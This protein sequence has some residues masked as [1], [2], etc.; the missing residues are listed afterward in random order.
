MQPHPPLGF[1]P[2]IFLVACAAEVPAEGSPSAT[3]VPASDTSDTSSNCDSSLYTPTPESPDD[4]TVV[5]LPATGDYAEHTFQVP[6]AQNWVN[7]GLY[8]KEGDIANISASGLWNATGNRETSAEGHHSETNRG[9]NIGQ[10]TARIGHHF[11]DPNVHCIGSEGVL[12]ADKDGIVYLGA[13]ISNDLGE[14][15]ESRLSAT[16]SIRVTVTSAGM[17]VPTV[18]SVDAAT[19]DFQRVESGWVEVRSEHIIL[20][21]PAAVAQ[22]D[23]DTLEAALFRL[24]TFYQL[25]LALR[26]ATPYLGQRIRFAPDPTADGWWMLAGN[27][28]RT[29]V[30]LQEGADD[31]RISRAGEEGNDN[32][33]YAHELGHTF[34]MVGGLW[35]YQVGG[36]LE[37][38]PNLF[39]LHALEQLEHPQAIRE[40]CSI[41]TES[42]FENG[43]YEQLAR[44]PWIG[45]CFLLTFKN[46]YGGWDFYK[47]FYRD[48]NNWY[49]FQ[50]PYGEPAWSW[51]RD[52][53]N[54]IAGEDTTY[55][56]NQWGVP[57]D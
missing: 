55:L 4:W 56:F 12:R 51:V 9:C 57:V 41:T 21:L 2:L 48:L 1:L 23:K 40:D 22:L 37:A 33:G 11:E 43:T 10:L 49:P 46:T 36:T 24:D 18:R 5:Y 50:V 45:L 31:V 20:T 14:T 15:Y 52:R 42:Y 7:T 54:A 13:M 39:T 34:T 47:A 35:T 30:D 44:D 16:G 28:V 27:P 38:W 8:L 26:D 6:A 17:T 25:H 32:W 3:D 29:M 53:F 19:Y